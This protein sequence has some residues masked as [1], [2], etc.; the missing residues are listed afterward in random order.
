MD[1]AQQKYSPV[2]MNPTHLPFGIPLLRL[3]LRYE[4]NSV[5]QASLRGLGLEMCQ[6]ETRDLHYQRRLSDSMDL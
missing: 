1:L 6:S 2:H 3:M 4:D 5:G